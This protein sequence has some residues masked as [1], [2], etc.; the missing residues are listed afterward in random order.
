M[1]EPA[2][3]C[4][5]PASR[6]TGVDA[7]MRMKILCASFAAFVALGLV[8]CQSDEQKISQ[9]LERAQAYYDGEQWPEAIIE[10]KNVLQIDPNHPQ[11]H[12][13]L[14]QAYL[15]GNK[16]REGFW[17]LRETVRLDPE[18]HDAKLQF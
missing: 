6:R 10:Y 16:P 2:P 5:A 4:G 9:H 13:K 3:R 17:E 11:A 8:A 1:V 18:N 14:S 12:W 15:K 7:S